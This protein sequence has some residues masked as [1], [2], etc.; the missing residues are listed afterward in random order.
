MQT[1]PDCWRMLKANNTVNARRLGNQSRAGYVWL[2][3]EWLV[4]RFAKIEINASEPIVAFRETVVPPPKVDMMS[5]AIVDTPENT[6]STKKKALIEITTPNKQC[7]LRIR[8]IPLPPAASELLENSAH[9]IKTMHR[10]RKGGQNAAAALLHN[11]ENQ[12]AL[13][14]EM[15]L[16]GELKDNMEKLRNDLK[17]A[18]KEDN[19]ND[20]VSSSKK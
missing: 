7:T 19:P 11:S 16:S 1:R 8:A 2:T 17:E 14:A 5:E 3:Y 13:P 18:C 9:M 10:S 20:T 15:V 4:C 6:S 12:P